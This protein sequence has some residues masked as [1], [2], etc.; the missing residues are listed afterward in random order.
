[1]KYITT[2]VLALGAGVA[3]GLT[4]AQAAPRKHALSPIAGR[5]NWYVTTGPVQ[6]KIG[7]TILSDAELP[8]AL[9]DQAETADKKAAK[10]RAQQQAEESAGAELAE[11]KALN[12]RLT[13]DVEALTKLNADLVAELQAVATAKAEAAEADAKAKADAEAQAKVKADADVATSKASTVG[14]KA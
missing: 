13:A 1:M 2:A 12:V 7:E 5:K 9:A 11:V 3:L 6:F 10:A 4:E 8:K 14:T